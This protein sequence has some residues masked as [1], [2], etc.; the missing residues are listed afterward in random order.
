MSPMG[1]RDAGYVLLR[2]PLEVREHYGEWLRAHY[3]GK[4]THVLS[5]LRA[6]AA[7]SMIRG[8]GRG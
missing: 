5:L 3:P 2:L 8:L 7:S 1:A 6:R 4:L